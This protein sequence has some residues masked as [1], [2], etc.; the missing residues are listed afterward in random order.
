MLRR[1]GLQFKRLKYDDPFINAY[2]NKA[3]HWLEDYVIKTLEE[4]LPG[5]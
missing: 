3:Q 4:I 2:M 1:E 5:M